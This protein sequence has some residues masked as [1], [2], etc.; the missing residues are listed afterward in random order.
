MMY[1]QL[2]QCDLRAI[3]AAAQQSA[4]SRQSHMQ[5]VPAVA[6][7]ADHFDYDFEDLIQQANTQVE[8]VL[9]RV[10]ICEQDSANRRQPEASREAGHS[11]VAVA[12]A[13]LAEELLMALRDCAALRRYVCYLPHCCTRIARCYSTSLGSSVYLLAS[14]AVVLRCRAMNDLTW[15]LSAPV[16]AKEVAA[17]VAW[18]RRSD[19]EVAT[20]MLRA[21][22]ASSDLWGDSDD[23]VT[24]CG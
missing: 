7:V 14:L 21:T 9:S 18:E 6:M 4:I 1:A 13:E 17:R 19:E 16:H 5:S 2:R 22:A 8:S 3:S 24:C 12:V 11:A 15:V 23:E 10:Y 20:A